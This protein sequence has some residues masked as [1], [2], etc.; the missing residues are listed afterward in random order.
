MGF[1]DDKDKS[2]IMN[3]PN[4]GIM[5]DK[6]LLVLSCHR[7]NLSMM[8]SRPPIP[9]SKAAASGQHEDTPAHARMQ[10]V[11]VKELKLSH[12]NGYI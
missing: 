7:Q 5:M 9:E 12:H 11:A 6:A 1:G 4:F 8:F 2:V 3:T 10:G